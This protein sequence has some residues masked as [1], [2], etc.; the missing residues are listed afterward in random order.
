M[1]IADKYYKQTVAASFQ[2]SKITLP[3]R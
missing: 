3:C 2:D 1:L